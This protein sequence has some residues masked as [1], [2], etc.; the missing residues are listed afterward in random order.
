VQPDKPAG[1]GLDA[2]SAPGGRG[3]GCTLA[4]A[5]FAPSRD[6]LLIASRSFSA[7]IAVNVF[8]LRRRR[9]LADTMLN[10]E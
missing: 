7:R 4:T 9:F 2:R 6:A 3:A 10:G 8:E 1:A 5:S